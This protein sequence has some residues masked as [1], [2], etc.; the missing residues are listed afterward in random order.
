M[1]GAGHILAAF[2]DAWSARDKAAALM[3]VDVDVIYA[4]H[5]PAETLPFGG[6]TTGRAAM[7][8]RMQ[9]IL[10]QFETR[11]LDCQITSADA[12]RA[13]A[14][15]TYCYRHWITGEEIDG[16]FRV[17]VAVRDGLIVTL[18]EFHDVERIRAFMRLVAYAAVEQ[19]RQR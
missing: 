8:D 7:S 13:V 5:V 15:F 3:F 14:K 18:D 1:V 6:L 2:S 12:D 17:I 19:S 11:R 10:D 9:T 4:M 16:T